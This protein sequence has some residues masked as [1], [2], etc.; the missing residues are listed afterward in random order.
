MLIFLAGIAIVKILDSLP[1]IETTL[2]FNLLMGKLEAI[3]DYLKDLREVGM[4]IAKILKDER[5]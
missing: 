4:K 5:W 2:F 3:I 1:S